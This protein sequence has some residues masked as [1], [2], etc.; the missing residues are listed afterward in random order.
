MS[1]GNL[2]DLYA[3][4][5][6]NP[7]GVSISIFNCK[8]GTLVVDTI[9][10]TLYQKQSEINDNSSYTEIGG[11]MLLASV[12]TVTGAKTFSG[13]TLKVETTNNGAG[14]ANLIVTSDAGQGL[15]LVSFDNADYTNLSGVRTD[16]VSPDGS[17]AKGY[18]GIIEFGGAPD[19]V[20]LA[21]PNGLKFI[22][23]TN[24]SISSG[25][26]FG[27][28][29]PDFKI[30]ITTGGRTGTTVFSNRHSSDDVAWHGTQFMPNME[31]SG[32]TLQ[33]IDTTRAGAMFQLENYYAQNGG[34]VAAAGVDTTGDFFQFTDIT[35]SSGPVNF[36]PC[37]LNIVSGGLPSGLAVS[38]PYWFF[39]VNNTATT[40]T[41][42]TLTSGAV[43]EI[44]TFVAGDS[45]TNVGAA[46]NASGVKFVSTGTTPTTYSNGSTLTK[47]KA[48]RLADSYANAQAGT[49]VNVTTQGTGSFTAALRVNEINWT[50]Q[51]ASGQQDR[52]FNIVAA[53]SDRSYGSNFGL[54]MPLS[55]SMP[56]HFTQAEPVAYFQSIRGTTDYTT[57]ELRGMNSGAGGSA[58]RLRIQAAKN[59][60]AVD[61]NSSWSFLTGITSGFSVTGAR[62]LYI[63][64]DVAGAFR[65]AIDSSGNIGIG[66]TS[67]G[68]SV[69]LD[70]SSTT[71]AFCPP[72]MTKA[73]R[74]AIG[75]PVASMMIY[76]TDNTPGLR[77]YNGT[78]WMRYTETAD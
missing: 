22:D 11:D 6:G 65:L 7:Q 21:E 77:T 55:V 24:A 34:T 13:S 53:A 19:A 2:Q 30:A 37:T 71:K 20:G 4:Y 36:Y 43:Y 48:F 35:G 45:F 44:T 47:L 14:S 78:N 26:T 67:P 64:D 39:A 75:T 76:Q 63:Y 50:I 58:S 49:A 25:W 51:T 41:S 15:N 16:Y 40:Q 73:Q 57:L 32:A 56:D 54:L 12:Q 68:A 52:L 18:F 31:Y 38:T 8:K 5:P 3:A 62:P 1:Q 28:S 66:T 29:A 17:L 74:D 72:R 61:L 27:G 9:N 69:L 33:R 23:I 46:S 70:L 10:G 60:S 59:G 42:G